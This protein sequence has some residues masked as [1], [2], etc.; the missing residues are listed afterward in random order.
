MQ[1][2][3]YDGFV[4]VDE[5]EDSFLS[6]WSEDDPMGQWFGS[7]LR[8]TEDDEQVLISSAKIFGT[9]EEAETALSKIFKAYTK[10]SGD[11]KVYYNLSVMP[12]NCVSCFAIKK[13]KE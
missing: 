5:E 3:S 2:V 1:E 6:E 13:E 9:K 10:D 4:I 12:V 8:E 11:V 7:Y